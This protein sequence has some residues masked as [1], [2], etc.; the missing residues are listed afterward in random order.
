MF[1]VLRYKNNSL[2]VLPTAV[3]THSVAVRRIPYFIKMTGYEDS[4]TPERT[5]SKEGL[6]NLCTPVS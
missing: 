6:Q 5:E 4:A 3:V 1:S 2:T